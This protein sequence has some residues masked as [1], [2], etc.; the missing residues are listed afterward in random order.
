MIQVS[1]KVD[2]SNTYNRVSSNVSFFYSRKN[3]FRLKIF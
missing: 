1:G 2:K 3:F